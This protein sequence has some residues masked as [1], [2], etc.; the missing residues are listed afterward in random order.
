MYLTGYSVS[1][2]DSP[3]LIRIDMSS[4]FVSASTVDPSTDQ[5]LPRSD[6]KGDEWTRAQREIEESRRRKQE[7]SRQESGKSLFE[8]LEAN[9]G[10]PSSIP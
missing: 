6:A 5:G 3:L 4:G 7:A 9:K 10:R 8:V 1:P 2:L